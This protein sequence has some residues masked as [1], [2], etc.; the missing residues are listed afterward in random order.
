[1]LKIVS[2]HAV[3]RRLLVRAALTCTRTN[4]SVRTSSH[5]AATAAVLLSHAVLQ[6]PAGTAVVMVAATETA[7]ETAA[8]LTQLAVLQL[9]V[10]MVVEPATVVETV[11]TLT[12][13]PAVL[14]LAVA[15]VAA[16]ATVVETA[17]TMAQAAVLQL[18]VATDAVT[19]AE[20]AM[21]AAAKAA[22]AATTTAAKSQS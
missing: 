14:Q 15:M 21:H 19:A 11:A 20:A 16:T 17:A 18:P 22:I 7:V 3:S 6:L 13:L 9:A 1:M 12:L 4:A 10:A 8:T 2:Q 5:L